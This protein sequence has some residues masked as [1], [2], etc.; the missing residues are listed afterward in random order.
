MYVP[1]PVWWF[2]TNSNDLNKEFTPFGPQAEIK[3]FKISSNTSTNKKID[4]S[5]SDN[6]IRGNDV[7]IDLYNNGIEVSQIN[8]VLSFGMLGRKNKRRLVPT[9]WSISATDDIIAS[10]LV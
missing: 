5:Y 10:Y 1:K 3:S 7:V 4:N 6:N 8:K 9:R 2:T